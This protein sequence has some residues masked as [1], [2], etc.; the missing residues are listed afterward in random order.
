MVSTNQ[1][2]NDNIIAA[3]IQTEKRLK[4]ANQILLAIRNVNQ[5]IIT[6]KDRDK[7]IQRACDELVKMRGYHSAWIA[8][9]NKNNSKTSNEP[10]KLLRIASANVDENF[11][12]II[13]KLKTGNLP[14]C[15]IKALNQSDVIIVKN[16][17]DECADC[18]LSQ[19]YAN[20]GSVVIRLEHNSEIY[21]LL[22]V[23]VPFSYIE[24][25][26]EVAL[27]EELAHDI[28][29]ALY[30]IESD[31]K[32]KQIEKELM[33]NELKFKTSL[34]NTKIAIY[35]QD[36][37]LRYI[38]IYNPQL[39]FK[40]EDILGKTS[41]EI[42]QLENA[43][44]LDAIKRKVMESGIGTR[45]IIRLIINGKPYFFDITI[46]PTI[47][48]NGDITGI[49]AASTDV[50]NLKM[51][52]N[53][54]RKQ[55]HELN[56][57]IKEIDCLYRI[58]SFALK[59]ISLEKILQGTVDIIPSAWLY[60][61]FTV[62]RIILENQ[63]FKTKNFKKTK[64]KQSCNI[65]AHDKQIG[66]LEVYYT[67]INESPFSQEESDLL[68]AIAE[69]LRETIERKRI[70]QEL[71]KAKELAESANRAKSDILARMSHEIR[72]PMNAIIGMGYLAMN[73]KLTPQQ[74]DYLSKIDL[75]ARA[76][77]NLINDI[78]DFSKIEA[79]KM[80]LEAINFQLDE[81]INQLVSMMNVK[82]VEKGINLIASVKE[83]TPNFL[84]GDPS[85][86]LQIFIN[87]VN[88]AIKF[89]K[90]GKV[91]ISVETI[92]EKANE[93]LLNFSV[94]DDGIGIATEY[95]P[96]LFQ[97]FSQENGSVN[98][99][100]GGSGLGLA[101]CNRLVKM[102]GGEITVKS[103]LGK[104][105]EFAFA[106]EF[107]KQQEQKTHRSMED[108]IMNAE[109]LQ[110]IKGAKIL[111]VEDN[112]INQQIAEEL[113]KVAGMIVEVANNGVEAVA[114]L[115]N[116]LFD[117]VLMD[118][119]MPEMDGYEAT[120][121]IRIDNKLQPKIP[122]IAMTAHA[123]VGDREK[124]M[125][126]GMNDY[127]SKPIEPDQ[128]F[129][130]LAKYIS[131]IVPTDKKSNDKK[132]EELPETLPGIDITSGLNRLL[133]N[134][135]FFKQLLLIF[136]KDYADVANKV[137]KA[138]HENDIE[139]A[140]KLLHS[141]KGVSGSVGAMDLHNISRELEAA[142]K[143]NVTNSDQLIKDFENALQIVL[144]SISTLDDAQNRQTSSTEKEPIDLS[145]AMPIMTELKS[146]LQEG[147]VEANEC[148]SAFKKL[149]QNSVVDKQITLLEKRIDNYDFDDALRILESVKEKIR[150]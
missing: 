40:A 137:K 145:K 96:L 24:D 21:G 113:L 138:F 56:E 27:F 61:E 102:M 26:E 120:R 124:C 71:I 131:K 133:G 89:T 114:I 35:S 141:M 75:S 135:K 101:I 29:F 2:N 4:H 18:P 136:K 80:E 70:R 86:L 72:T 126:V 19:D 97:V 119:Q 134:K 1:N 107:K 128:L 44:N 67:G 25:E 125:N 149:L 77:L 73:T 59:N 41:S 46:E 65:I 150:E 28:A 122:I 37:D 62:A 52:E 140:L 51:A 98:R 117:A 130:V 47:N 112:K 14:N 63:E 115:E 57:R 54:L 8:L 78:L 127:V 10:R 76:L 32:R 13:D 33:D 106:L 110:Q 22:T 99:K 66:V 15:T 7:L 42:S 69:R 142:V 50:T 92:N 91:I 121:Q 68:K 100:Y 9:F 111:V 139:Q 82:A 143:K 36:K 39:G 129:A 93:A 6:E 109:A 17:C 88:N 84:I 31:K 85:R 90:T 38:W 5:I 23:S 81:T 87:L 146:L 123:M 79:G 144:Q 45:D 108:K 104:G 12:L 118:I 105:S 48:K 64:W 95:I 34:K 103:E 16:P 11:Q 94:K 3:H 74:C 148:V 53:V 43:Y 147:D 60:P 116:S 58:S 20:R 49:I 30:S 55:T 132:T 83:D